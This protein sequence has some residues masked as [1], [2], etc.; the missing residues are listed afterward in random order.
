MR[1]ENTVR[2]SVMKPLRRSVHD[3]VQ[4]VKSMR[5][6][7]VDHLLRTHQPIGW[8]VVVD[9]ARARQFEP[10]PLTPRAQ[11]MELL[12]EL[13]PVTTDV[14]LIR[15]GPLA[16]GGYLVPDDLD[17][18]VACFSPGVSVVSRFEFDCA[19]RA[20]DVFM[21]DASVDGPAEPHRRFHFVK[22]FLGAAESHDTIRFDAW[23]HDS[24][25]DRTGDLILQMDIEG[26][27][28]EVL[29]TIS[30]E[31]MRRFRVIVI[32][33][34]QLDDLHLSPSFRHLAP[35]IRQLLETH[36]C[37]HIHPNN[38]A[39]SVVLNDVDLP[40]VAEFTFVRRDRCRLTGYASHFPHPL[41]SD[42]TTT[43]Q[44]LVLSPHLVH[45]AEDT[46]D[47]EGNEDTGAAKIRIEP[48]P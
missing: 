44:Q 39:D 36:V 45:G 4:W 33:L 23:V 28:W 32:E 41:D 30:P 20:M 14:P 6:Q 31:L 46:D 21:A 13:H 26:A 16:D 11:L 29:P 9:V 18:I 7:R 25:G 3:C 34:H 1:N 10:V 24:L 17:G 35:I 40:Q 8:Q 48:S 22:R 38:C 43:R 5:W 42:N 37:V 19:E 27:E 47:G 15:L 2:R 12:A